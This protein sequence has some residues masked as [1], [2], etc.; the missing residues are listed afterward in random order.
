MSNAKPFEITR[1]LN[2]P[3]EKVWKAITETNEMKKWYFDLAEFKPEVGFQFQFSGGPPEKSYLHLCEVTEVIKGK[4]LT[5]SWRYD[6]YAGN[7]F[8]TF[9]LFEEGDKTRLTL[10]H[11]GLETFPADNPHFDKKNF[12]MG[13]THI[14]GKSLPEYFETVNEVKGNEIRMER[15]LNAPREVVWKVWTQPEHLVKW[16]GPKGFSTAIH[17]IEVQPG[18]VWHLTMTGPDGR[19]YLNKMVFTEVVKPE[20]LVFKHTGEPGAEKSSHVTTVT[21]QERGDK[22]KLSMV[23]TF[24]SPEELQRI[25]KEYGA[26]QGGIECVGRMIDYLATV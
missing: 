1:M 14:I 22:T 13:W 24:D 17:K 6:G 9:E 25:E 7:S 16:W 4:K 19:D 21:F 12:E 23:M 15:L 10:T 3:I 11:V 2:A 26:I 20:R 18:G 8:V 5:Y